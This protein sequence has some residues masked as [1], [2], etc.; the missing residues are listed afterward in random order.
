MVVGAAGGEPIRPLL[1]EA[2]R[3]F[4]RGEAAQ[5][6]E[7]VRRAW[8]KGE[9]TAEERVEAGVAYARVLWRVRNKPAA[10]RKVLGAARA[11]KANPA[12]PW[13][14]LAELETASGRYSVACDA[15]RA[16]LPLAGNSN[17][18][19]EARA[20][21]GEAMCAEVF[22]TVLRGGLPATN[23]ALLG[24]VREGLG[25]LEPVMQNEPGWRAPS[26]CQIL[27]ALLAG[28]GNAALRAWHSYFLLVPGEPSPRPHLE[29]P[30]DLGDLVMENGK[31]NCR[32]VV[33]MEPEAILEKLLPDFTADSVEMR[34]KV[35]RALAGGRL[36]PE[37]ATLAVNWGL[38]GDKTID[39]III[40]GR[41]YDNLSRR[42]ENEYRRHAQGKSYWHHVRIPGVL[43]WDLGKTSRVERLVQ[44]EL[45]RLWRERHPRPNAPP[46]PAE[47][48]G[49]DL[50]ISF[51]AV[52]RSV[53]APDFFS[54]SHIIMTSDES[55]EQ[56]GRTQSMHCVTLDSF[57][58]N[59]YGDW[60]MG[61][62]GAAL[63]GWAS[64]PSGFA[65][66]RVDYPL[67]I[68][69]AFV[70]PDLY[71]EYISE[72]LPGLATE[73]EAR[74]RT[75]ACGYFPGLAL[76][77]F[78]R[79]NERLLERLKAEGLSGVELRTAFL[80]E[81]QRLL[82]PAHILA[83]EGRHVFDM[84]DKPGGYS[85]AEL[86]FRAKCSEIVFA[87]DPLLIAGV[88]NIFS[89]NIGRKD[90]GHGSANTRIMKLLADWMKVHSAEIAALDES[91][92]L[93][94]QFDRL[95]DDQMRAAFRAMD[96][97]GQA[98]AKR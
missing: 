85:G 12:R 96:P 58:C 40:Y 25:L 21:F 17:E 92:P 11:L 59:G 35:V 91:R 44:S 34:L 79:G 10:A 67:N 88:G 41:W 78:V 46:Y 36:F 77:L 51:G 6:E 81:R 37:A 38:K 82:R 24:R 80:Q 98:E 47:G 5:G 30:R 22:E 26:R 72:R 49:V 18:K 4:A 19:R 55:I 20:R 83:H 3:R 70:D 39:D 71:R 48:S 23:S 69:E 14:E 63:G 54:F 42:V 97:R 60:L 84:S 68:F 73:D 89:P 62:T 32:P 50:A 31:W 95:T 57:I 9:G 52:I 53:E 43:D 29:N 87:P 28:D 45:R 15:A 16:A 94:P 61:F 93:L 7:L 33:F 56:Y 75:N 74:A 13:L 90:N 86:E 64:P 66:V 2:T 8:L 65:E 76:R 27:L 1:D